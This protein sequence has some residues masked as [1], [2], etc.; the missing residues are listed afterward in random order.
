M[1]ERKDHISK[2]MAI[3]QRGEPVSFIGVTYRNMVEGLLRGA[4]VTQRQLA[5]S[6]KPT[7]V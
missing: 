4:E 7:P 3:V 1:P 2:S 5:A 6:P